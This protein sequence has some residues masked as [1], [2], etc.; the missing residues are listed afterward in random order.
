MDRKDNKQKDHHY[1]HNL[2]NALA[3]FLMSHIYN[4][5][6]EH[7]D[8]DHADCYQ[9]RLSHKLQKNYDKY[10]FCFYSDV[11][12]LPFDMAQADHFDL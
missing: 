8:Q 6:I 3:A 4:A 2:D 9:N 10:I 1:H 12:L 11:K 5:E 7:C